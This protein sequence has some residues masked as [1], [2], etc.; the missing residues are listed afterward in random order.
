[1]C[2][3]LRWEQLKQLE[4]NHHE[5]RTTGKEGE[6]GH[7]RHKH[8]PRKRRN[9]SMHIGY[10]GQ[11]EGQRNMTCIPIARQQQQNKQLYNNRC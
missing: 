11:I 8:S 3:V 10:L 9:G 2:A 1:M 7:K 6:T 5:N 4:S